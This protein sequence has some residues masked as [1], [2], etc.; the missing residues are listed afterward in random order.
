MFE[1][2]FITVERCV[3]RARARCRMHSPA[4]RSLTSL[5]SRISLRR[6]IQG[7]AAKQ[8]GQFLC[9]EGPR[10]ETTALAAKHLFRL[11]RRGSK[12]VKSQVLAGKLSHMDGSGRRS[13]AVLGDA[14]LGPNPL[15]GQQDDM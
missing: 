4:S 2:L 11:F 12:A 13:R 7:T 10:G 1:W 15:D 6:N 5:G 3:L 14:V 8:S 9:S